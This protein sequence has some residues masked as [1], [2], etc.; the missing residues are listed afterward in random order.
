[1]TAINLW[2]YLTKLISTPVP[3]LKILRVDD[4]L[5]FDWQAHEDSTAHGMLVTRGVGDAWQVEALRVL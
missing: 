5:A 1:M 4:P 2:D 3:D